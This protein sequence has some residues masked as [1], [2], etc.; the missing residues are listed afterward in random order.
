MAINLKSLQ[1]GRSELCRWHNRVCR[2]SCGRRRLLRSSTTIIPPVIATYTVSMV[3]LPRCGSNQF[4]HR[5]PY[6][7]VGNAWKDKPREALRSA[8]KAMGLP[9]SKDVCF[10]A[11]GY[12]FCSDYTASCMQGIATAY[13]LGSSNGCFVLVYLPYGLFLNHEVGVLSIR[14]R[15]STFLGFYP[16]AC[17]IAMGEHR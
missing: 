5:P 7:N 2:Q 10:L 1:N 4:M 6:L 15:Q 17:S 12:G 11:N 13:E 3:R 9:A 16:W 14:D 8:R